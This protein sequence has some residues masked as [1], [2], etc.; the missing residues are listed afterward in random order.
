MSQP[1]SDSAESLDPD[2]ALELL[3]D[4]T[5]RGAVAVLREEGPMALGELAAET[6]A[7]RD[8]VATEDVSAEQR[9]RTAATLHNAHLPKLA[10]ADVAS[11]DPD[12]NRIE[13]DEAI[14]GL[15]RY[16][17][18]IDSYSEEP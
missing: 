14:A 11:Y 1:D 4:A 6:V 2:V 9:K 7:R 3:S 13:P 17:E 5:R 8:G 15:D 12:A 10:G 16:F 18:V